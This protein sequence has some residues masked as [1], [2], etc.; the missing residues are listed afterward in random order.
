MFLK[1]TIDMIT[2]YLAIT[3]LSCESG[4]IK[5]SDKEIINPLKNS[6]VFFEQ[7]FIVP[8]T[9]TNDSIE[10]RRDGSVNVSLFKGNR[11]FDI[12]QLHQN[13][14]VNGLKKLFKLYK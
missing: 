5:I 14:R 7:N 3:V 10:F 9:N 2:V 6:K 13:H 1:R 8:I 11:V 12:T 4:A